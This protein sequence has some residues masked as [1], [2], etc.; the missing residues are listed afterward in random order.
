[1]TDYQSPVSALLNCGQCDAKAEWRDYIAEFNFTE[2]HIPELIRMATDEELNYSEPDSKQVW[3]PTHAWR[4]LAQLKASSAIKPLLPLLNNRDDEW[5][6]GDFPTICTMVGLDSIPFLKEFLADTNNDF[7]ARIDVVRCLTDLTKK[8]PET[9]EDHLQ[10]V[11]Q[12]LEKFRDNDPI[13]NSFL[14]IALIDLQAV[15]QIDLIEQVFQA[16]LVDTFVTGDWDDVQVDFGL[17]SAEEVY[18]RRLTQSQPFEL[19][20][21]T[22]HQSKTGKGFSLS[23]SSSNKSKSRKSSQKK[24]KR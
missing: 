12:Q 21:A 22:P 10:V 14:V 8:Y 2:E 15:E 6:S 9:H 20:F 13:F 24:K 5:I 23:Q 1:M 16:D 18:T 19:S 17:K 4:A 7:F 11:V 3:A